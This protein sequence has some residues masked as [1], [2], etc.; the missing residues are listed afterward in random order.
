M[1]LTL[2]KPTE[3]YRPPGN[4][5]S[6]YGAHQ[7]VWALRSQSDQTS[8]D[9]LFRL[10]ELPAPTLYVLAPEP[11]QAPGVD[12]VAQSTKYDFNPTVEQSFAFRVRVNATVMRQGKRHSIVADALR[13]NPEESRQDVTN[14]AYL[15]WMQRQGD[16]HGFNVDADLFQVVKHERCQVRKKDSNGVVIDRGDLGGQVQ[17][18]DAAKFNEMLTNG[19]GR[20]KSFGCGLMQIQPA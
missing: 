4:F 13:N 10:D 15:A 20:S 9:F 12:W 8:R 6:V 5:D 3:S 2:L 7:L 17:V 1:Y 11:I 16:Q 19:L 18:T 14:A